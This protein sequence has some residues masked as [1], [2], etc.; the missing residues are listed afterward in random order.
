M[1]AARYL[2]TY[3]QIIS[4]HYGGLLSPDMLHKV[5]FQVSG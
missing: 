4:L 5:S 1:T 3:Y 2:L